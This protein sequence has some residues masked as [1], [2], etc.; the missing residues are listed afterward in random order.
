MQPMLLQHRHRH[1][2]YLYLQGMFP[3]VNTTLT[4]LPLGVSPMSAR[5]YSE[6]TDQEMDIW[7]QV[8]KN[9]ALLTSAFQSKTK[10]MMDFD[11]GFLK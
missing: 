7:L 8:R 3:T 5:S 10:K 6:S 9:V 1:H 11:D 4:K 2:H